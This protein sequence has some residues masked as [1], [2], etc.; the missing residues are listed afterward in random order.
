[1]YSAEG[2]TV[3]D[4]FAGLGTTNVACM[5]SNRNSIGVDIDPEIVNL[6]IENMGITT[7]A[8]NTI[9]NNRIQRHLEFIAALPDDKKAKC[10]ENGP[11]GF[12]V[13]TRQETAIEIEQLKSIKRT[14]SGYECHYEKY[15][16]IQRSEQM[17]LAL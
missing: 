1:M 16:P 9:I 13:K 5:I 2:D 11:H 4:P 8:A 6:A 7:E 10:Y 15:K 17:S 3:L 12:N 14:E